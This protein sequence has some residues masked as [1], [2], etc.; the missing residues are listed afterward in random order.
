MLYFL[1]TGNQYTLVSSAFLLIFSP[2]FAWYHLL[3]RTT[4]N[5]PYHATIILGLH[6]LCVCRFEQHTKIRRRVW[7]C[8]STYLYAF[9]HTKHISCH[10]WQTTMTLNANTC[11]TKKVAWLRSDPDSGTLLSVHT[12]IIAKESRLRVTHNNHQKWT[13]VSDFG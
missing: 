7:L 1:S 5:M 8:V 2:C 9:V 11:Y 10:N 3:L 13:L 6:A 4:H 12:S